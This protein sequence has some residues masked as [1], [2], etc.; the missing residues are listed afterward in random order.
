MSSNYNK[1]FRSVYKLT[2]H[3]VLVTKYRKKAISEKI[4]LRLKEIFTETLI[5]WE[6]D[7]VEF[8]GES[9]HVH[10]LIDYK[11]DISLSKLI[12]N[13]KTVSSRLI[14]RDFP[15]LASKYFDNKPYFWTGAYFVASCGGVTVS[16]LKK[17]V[18]TQ[19]T[20]Q[21]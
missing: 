6:C 11:P 10:L 21:E 19:K 9:D 15:E 20:P 12:A 14:R 18:E 3:V 2:A 8:N 17:Y 5:K 13:L 4:L 1:G 16:Q 7:L